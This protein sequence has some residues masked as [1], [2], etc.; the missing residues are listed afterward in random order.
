MLLAER[1]NGIRWSIQPTPLIPAA[2]DMG[3]PSIACPA[4][5]WCSAVGGRT[6]DGGNP[7]T[8]A[9]QWRGGTTASAS[10]PALTATGSGPVCAPP[11]IAATDRELAMLGGRDAR[12]DSCLGDADPVSFMELAAYLAPPRR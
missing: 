10:R 4:V 11:V 1:W 7:V 9:E 5:S 3:L 12:S 6:S 8:L 2:H